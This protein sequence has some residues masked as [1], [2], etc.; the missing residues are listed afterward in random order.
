MQTYNLQSSSAVFA[1]NIIRFAQ[2]LYKTQPVTA[3]NIV[4]TWELPIEAVEQIAA[5][6]ARIEIDGETVVA[7][8]GEL[9]SFGD[10]EVQDR[11][12]I[13]RAIVRQCIADLL[14]AGYFLTV[15]DGESYPVDHSRDAAEI[16]GAMFSV[17]QEVLIAYR[18]DGKRVGSVFFVYGNDGWDVINDYSTGLEDALANTMALAESLES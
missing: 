9:Q 7:T 4:K 17:D 15:D 1:P 11:Q 10:P 5:G 8:V 16:L 14:A 18:L 6:E 3:V 2:H 13:E 12:T